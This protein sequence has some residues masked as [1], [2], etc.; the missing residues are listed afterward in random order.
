MHSRLKDTPE[1]TKQAAILTVPSEV[2]H[3]LFNM[4]KEEVKGCKGGKWVA[5]STVHCLLNGGNWCQLWINPKLFSTSQPTLTHEAIFKHNED[6]NKMLL[7]R[8]PSLPASSVPKY[9]GNENEQEKQPWGC[10][11]VYIHKAAGRRWHLRPQPL[12]PKDFL[13]CIPLRTRCVGILKT[14]CM[15]DESIGH[16]SANWGSSGSLKEN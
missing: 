1:W 7:L 10:V 16:K 2:K 12:I 11:L 3:R 8:T 4:S 13:C 15:E 5:F 6:P 14:F 9:P